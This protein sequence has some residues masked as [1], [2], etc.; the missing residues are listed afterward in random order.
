MVKW[1]FRLRGGPYDGTAVAALLLDSEARPAVVVAW[2]CNPICGGHLSDPD[3]EEINPRTAVAYR[4]EEDDEAA[5][6]AVYVA[7]DFEPADDR[8]IDVEALA[9]AGASTSG[10]T[11]AVEQS[12]RG[13]EFAR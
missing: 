12:A 7:G 4:L 2:L 13:R 11:R 9:G 1:E 6:V 8:E 3:D 10:F 5:M